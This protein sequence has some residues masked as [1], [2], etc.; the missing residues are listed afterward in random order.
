MTIKK[1]RMKILT[2]VKT[3]RHS[4]F[5]ASFNKLNLLFE[6]PASL[7]AISSCTLV[8]RYSTT[9]CELIVEE[10]KGLKPNYIKVPE[11]KE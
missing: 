11:K 7:L 4:I 2:F 5:S 6:F 1:R 10:G 3:F 8:M 9:A